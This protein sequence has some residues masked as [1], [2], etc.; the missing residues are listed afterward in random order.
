MN[1][2][3]KFHGSVAFG[4]LVHFYTDFISQRI[5]IYCCCLWVKFVEVLFL[6]T[7][8]VFS[9]L[10]SINSIFESLVCHLENNRAQKSRWKRSAAIMAAMSKYYS[11]IMK[12]NRVTCAR[13]LHPDSS[14]SHFLVKTLFTTIFRTSQFFVPLYFV[15]SSSRFVWI[16]CMDSNTKSLSLSQLPMLANYK[17]LTKEKL[18]DVF[19]IFVSSVLTGGST[20]YIA[21]LMICFLS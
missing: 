11:D 6:E 7:R 4:V 8:S 21:F 3:E 20:V 13:A 18:F 16:Q 12:S 17:N 15:S 10:G 19:E 14:C 9:I 2:N 5:V 1:R